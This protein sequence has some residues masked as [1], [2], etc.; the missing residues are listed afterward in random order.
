[1]IDDDYLIHQ[2][3]NN[4]D[5]YDNFRNRIASLHPD[6]ARMLGQRLGVTINPSDPPEVQSQALKNATWKDFR[7]AYRKA[8]SRDF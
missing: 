7:Y 3:L 2:T 5:Q 8:T 4:T 6:E 1:M